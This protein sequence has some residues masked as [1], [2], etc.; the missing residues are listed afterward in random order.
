ME[1]LYSL[2]LS[3]VSLSL[4]FFLFSLTFQS[5]EAWQRQEEAVGCSL[6]V[7]NFDKT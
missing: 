7:M 2:A 5:A 4:G 6:R 1:A 3:L